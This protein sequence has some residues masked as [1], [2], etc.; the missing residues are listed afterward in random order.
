M[1]NR[2]TD[3]LIFRYYVMTKP[4]IEDLFSFLQVSCQDFG[5]NYGTY[6]K[7]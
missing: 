3:I 1:K 2:K 4:L 5:R 7:S 6:R